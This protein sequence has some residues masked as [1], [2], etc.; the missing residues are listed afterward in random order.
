MNKAR[1]YHPLEILENLTANITACIICL[2]RFEMTV[3]P[4]IY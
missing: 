3:F 1:I 2:D 4:I